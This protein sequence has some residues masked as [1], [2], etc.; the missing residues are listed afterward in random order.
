[1]ATDIGD[2]RVRTG[3]G[4]LWLGQLHIGMAHCSTVAYGT[5]EGSGSQ[6]DGPTDV[7][8]LDTTSGGLGGGGSLHTS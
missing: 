5:V 8:G 2:E 4:L 7:A 1:M 6:N 3:S